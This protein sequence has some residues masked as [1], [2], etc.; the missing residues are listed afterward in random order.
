MPEYDNT[1]T[2]EIEI[3]NTPILVMIT[4]HN[5]RL[6]LADVM[7]NHVNHELLYILSGTAT[8]LY[9]NCSVPLS[10]HLL[11][12]VPS[13]LYHQIVERSDD[14]MIAS[15]RFQFKSISRSRD[16]KIARVI[17]S[18]A[19]FFADFSYQSFY[20]ELINTFFTDTVRPP[21]LYKDVLK[22]EITLLFCHLFEQMIVL[23]NSPENAKES[24]ASVSNEQNT[25]ELIEHILS[26]RYMEKL[27]L[28]DIAGEINM[29]KSYT[30]RL[31]K[32]LYGISF[33]QKLTEVRLMMAQRL[34][35]ETD[36][37]LYTIAERCG[38]PSYDHFSKQFKAVL[39][40]TPK[41]FKQMISTSTIK[42]GSSSEKA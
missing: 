17:P 15:L 2:M 31:I 35:R 41:E 39:G 27:C 12:L 29:S 13:S 21:L 33:S 9:N 19:P 10:P 14:L 22:S 7:H 24:A 11:C 37:R 32:K 30:L 3:D 25:I 38:Y 34:I 1:Y 42:T 36:E 5:I 18:N 26:N 4:L 20:H 6:N 16:S 40:L 8:L 23:S 28:E